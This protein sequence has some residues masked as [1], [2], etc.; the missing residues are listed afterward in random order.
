MRAFTLYTRIAD[1][2]LRPKS[3]V[4]YNVLYF[5]NVFP[6]HAFK[7]YFSLKT[8]LI[9]IQI[10]SHKIKFK[11]HHGASQKSQIS[12]VFGGS[13]PKPLVSYNQSTLLR[14]KSVLAQ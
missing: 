6:T 10:A 11:L 9:V 8:F 4:Y 12:T 7:I 3:H 14:V 13:S 2:S 5:Q 1:D